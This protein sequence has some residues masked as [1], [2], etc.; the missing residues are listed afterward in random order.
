MPPA[1]RLDA[2]VYR[3]RRQVL[4]N[5]I[6]PKNALLIHAPPQSVRNGSVH[7]P[8]RQTSDI[9]YLTGFAEPETTL[10]LRPGADKEQ[11]MMFV[12]DRDPELEVWDGSRAGPK[13]AVERYGADV[14][15]P[16]SELHQR[17]PDLLA[18]I[19]SLYYSLGIYPSCDHL[20]ASTIAHMR[21]SER[22]GKAPPRAVVDPRGMLHEMRLYKTSEEQ[23]LLRHAANIAAKG[24]IAAMQKASPGVHEYELAALIEFIFRDHGGDG[25]GYQS[26]V[27]SGT[28]ATVLHYVDNTS[29]LADGDLVLIDAGCE[30]QSYTVDITRTFPANGQFSPAQRRCY[31]LVLDTQMA[32]IDSARPGVTI[33]EIHEQC[34]KRLTEGMVELGLLPGPVDKHLEEEDY[35]RFYMHRTSHWLGMDVHD[36]G[37][38]RRGNYARPL[39][40][41]MVLTI[42]PGLYIPADAPEE[43]SEYRGI[44]IRIEDDVLITASGCENLTAAVPKAPDDVERT[45]RRS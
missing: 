33:D 13:G 9:L 12:R 44:G 37:N 31:E 18:N 10:L 4:L 14:A 41:G 30:Y 6:G 17:L 15:F 32:A 39:E 7:H 2:R 23:S 36:V 45:C 34:V 24:H 28:N 42:E 20:V 1:P 43:C 25:P 16:T 26:I 40:P 11:V 38:Y 8:Y 29:A 21:R 27:G 22:K 19:D 35:K 3:Q 5:A